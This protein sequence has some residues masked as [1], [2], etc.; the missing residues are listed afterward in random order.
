MG[1]GP[2]WFIGAV[3]LAAFGVFLRFAVQALV[4]RKYRS[5][6]AWFFWSFLPL[7][8]VCFVLVATGEPSVSDAT[9]NLILGLVGAAFGA[10]ASI[11]IGYAVLGIAANA[12]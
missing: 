7:L 3:G 9:R 6:A 2:N 10:S 1:T 11:W 8:V 4:D 5:S 12:Q